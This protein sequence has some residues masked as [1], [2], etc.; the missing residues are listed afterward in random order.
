MTS[1]QEIAYRISK[2]NRGYIYLISI[3]KIAYLTVTCAYSLQ[4][5]AVYLTSILVPANKGAVWAEMALW[6]AIFG[7]IA[8][9]FMMH[10]TSIH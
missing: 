3:L 9:Y 5:C 2:S 8:F 4:F 1:Y 10:L 7:A 6:C